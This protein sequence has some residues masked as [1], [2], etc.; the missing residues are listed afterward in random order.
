MRGGEAH[1]S[2]RHSLSAAA[3][4]DRWSGCIAGVAHV[5]SSSASSAPE[6]ADAEAASEE[7]AGAGPFREWSEMRSRHVARAR[8]EQSSGR[9]V[10]HAEASMATSAAADA[11]QARSAAGSMGDDKEARAGRRAASSVAVSA[12]AGG[13]GVAYHGGQSS[14]GRV[15]DAQGLAGRGH[16]SPQ[17]Q[18]RGGRNTSG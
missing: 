5:D 16:A 1:R 4:A 6:S 12:L 3:M 2:V 14:V 15:H 18:T 11:E 9:R 7:P 13:G 10:W 17:R 8:A